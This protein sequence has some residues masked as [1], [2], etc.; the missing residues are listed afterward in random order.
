MP[1]H[2]VLGHELC[3]HAN[4][5]DKGNHDPRPGTKGDRP[6][7]NQAIDEENILRIEQKMTK[8]RGRYGNPNKG[9]STAHERKK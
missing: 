7:H 5:F 8:M 2:K 6:G 9:E 1:F 3:G 4:H